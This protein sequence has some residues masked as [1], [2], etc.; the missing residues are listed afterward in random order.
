MTIGTL[1]EYFVDKSKTA[2]LN[3]WEAVVVAIVVIVDDDV[4][5][6][7]DVVVVACVVET[8]GVVVRWLHSKKSQ[9]HPDLQLALNI[10]SEL[11]YGIIPYE[12]HMGNH[13]F[14]LWIA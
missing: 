11:N 12:P 9:G 5:I 13:Q 14:L 3:G 2:S 8:V 1:L 6:D 4:V 7:V 10:I